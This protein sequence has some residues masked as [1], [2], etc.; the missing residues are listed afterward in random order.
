MTSIRLHIIVEGQTEEQFVNVLLR[1]HLA[2]SPFNVW[3]D[4]R[5]IRSGETHS[6][7]HKGGLLSF[8]HLQ[9]DIAEWIRS[10]QGEDARFTTMVDL[11]GYPKNAP[12]YGE[13]AVLQPYDR[14]KRLEQELAATIGSRRFL[15][16]IQLH[17]FETLLYADLSKWRVLLP[18][19]ERQI[20]TL[21]ASVEAFDSIELID[22]GESTAPSKRVLQ[23]FPD[24]DKALW[25]VV[26]ALEISLE[27]MRNKCAHFN[28]WLTGL[29]DLGHV[30]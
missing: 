21:A 25:G 4:A 18:G 15:P 14:V 10:D 5:M 30:H 17:E 27:A 1:P 19:N 13:A 8:G 23:A 26:L 11:Y 16:Y 9:R 24:Y 29:E 28:A 20:R 12:G 22:D 7:R 2:Q 6:R 3:V